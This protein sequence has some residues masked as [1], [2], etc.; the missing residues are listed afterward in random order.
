M[1]REARLHP[2]VERYLGPVAVA[3]FIDMGWF[4]FCPIG[5]TKGGRKAFRA[6][7]GF[8]DGQEQLLPI[9]TGSTTRIPNGAAHWEGRV[10]RLGRTTDDD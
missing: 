6:G 7:Y 3:Q 4:T 10:T 5:L 2:R 9:H 1:S 8:W